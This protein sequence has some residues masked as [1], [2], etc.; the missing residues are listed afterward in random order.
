LVEV[1]AVASV[2][3]SVLLLEVVPGLVSVLEKERVLVT[4]EL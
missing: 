1:S 3:A 2:E 4:E